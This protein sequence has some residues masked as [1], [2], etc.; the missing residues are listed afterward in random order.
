MAQ[1]FLSIAVPT[2]NRHDLLK[3]TLD[4]ITAQGFEDFEV[5]VGNDYTAEL[6]TCEQ[7]G[8]S[9]HRIRIINHPRNLREVGNMNALLAEAKGRYFTWLFDDDLYEPGFLQA[10]YKAIAESNFPP[11]LFSSY[12]VIDDFGNRLKPVQ[13][14]GKVTIIDG[15]GL[16]DSYF[17]RNLEIISTCGMFDRIML[18]KEIGGVEELCNSAIGL[19]C[20][21]LFLVRCGL[22]SKIAY[23]DSQ[24]VVFRAHA[25]S[26]GENNTELAKYL[27]AGQNLISRSATLLKRIY[28]QRTYTP[29]LI[30]LGRIHLLSFATKLV[31]FET[32]SGASDLTTRI[33]TIQ[34]FNREATAIKS[35]CIAHADLWNIRSALRFFSIRI[36][37]Y[38]FIL[39][40]FRVYNRQ[41][42]SKLKSTTAYD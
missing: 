26:W 3:Q 40:K 18:T 36:Y 25:G 42:E 6:L 31:A 38:R 16:L 12:R 20:E 28:R 23:L 7:L 22:F 19:Y 21:Y 37:C 15:T 2:Y 5:I 39:G 35:V 33:R 11:A 32:A 27:E 13:G 41:I 34:R 8:I 9:D 14:N 24:S 17:S 30:G 4:S 10:A 1:P 29:I